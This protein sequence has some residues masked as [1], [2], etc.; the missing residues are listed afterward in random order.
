MRRRW[1]VHWF[2]YPFIR[3]ASNLFLRHYLNNRKYRNIKG[4]IDK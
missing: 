2:K 1:R 4:V 3:P